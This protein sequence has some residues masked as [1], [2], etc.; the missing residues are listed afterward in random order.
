MRAPDEVKAV[1]DEFSKWWG[2][3]SSSSS[4]KITRGKKPKQQGKLGD[5]AAFF[6]GQDDSPE[7]KD[8]NKDNDKDKDKDNNEETEDKTPS[9]RLE[10]MTKAYQ[11]ETHLSHETQSF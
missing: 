11:C 2:A 9:S 7:E 5:K 10:K 1:E 6:E 3:A 8:K 4:N